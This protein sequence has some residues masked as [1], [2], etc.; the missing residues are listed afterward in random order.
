MKRLNDA[1]RGPPTDAVPPPE[2]ISGGSGMGGR[3]LRTAMSMV[4]E[5]ARTVSVLPHVDPRSSSSPFSLPPLVTGLASQRF[6]FD[7]NLRLAAQYVAPRLALVGDAA[8]TMH[9]MA[10]LGLN[11]GLQDAKALSDILSGG[12]ESGIDIGSLQQLKV[13][14]SQRMKKNEWM[15]VALQGIHWLFG[16]SEGSR[17][18]LRGAGMGAINAL[19]I[20]LPRRLLSRYAMGL[21]LGQAPSVK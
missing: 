17:A 18:V 8:H 13:Y 14:E 2:R 15:A 20:T 10:G 21:G 11:L 1:F 3:L 16:S 9:P 4:A 7:L 6:G 19:P 12:V 5:G